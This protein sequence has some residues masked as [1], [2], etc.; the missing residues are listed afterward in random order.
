[1]DQLERERERGIVV[2][3]EGL[4]QPLLRGLVQRT[5]EILA[6]R[7]HRDGGAQASARPH[8]AHLRVQNHEEIGRTLDQ[9]CV[10]TLHVRR[11]P[12]VDCTTYRGTSAPRSERMSDC[13]LTL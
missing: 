6:R 3:R 1:M 2:K 7:H 10:E 13:P 9:E 12:G 11:L 8:D 4:P 5:E